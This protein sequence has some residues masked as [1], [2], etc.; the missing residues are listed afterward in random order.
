MSFVCDKC[1]KAQ[2][3]NT[4]P[5]VVV[6]ETRNKIYPETEFDRGGSGW[7]IVKVI[8]VC[9]ACVPPPVEKET[10]ETP[11]TKPKKHKQVEEEV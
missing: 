4:T 10:N 7:E 1:K 3:H 9:K 11:A 2:P 8:H 5:E 6:T